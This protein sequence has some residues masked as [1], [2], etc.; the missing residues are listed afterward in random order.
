[1]NAAISA[2]V[3]LASRLS[4]DLAV[5]ALILCSV[6]LFA[7]F[8]MLR[9]RFQVDQQFFVLRPLNNNSPKGNLY[10]TAGGLDIFV[11]NVI[12]FDDGI[13]IGDRDVHLLGYAHFC[14]VPCTRHSDLGTKVQKVCRHSDAL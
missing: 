11:V 12:H 1:M 6:Q 10:S 14:S 2:S 8:P 4:N 7:L 3:V 13:N 5:F 9:H